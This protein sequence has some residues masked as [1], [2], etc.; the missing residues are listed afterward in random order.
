MRSKKPHLSLVIPVF[1]EEGNLAWH[2]DQITSFLE[3]RQYPY[4]LL[5]VDDGSSDNS[6]EIIKSICQKD[7]NAHY[8][9]FS[10][11][12]GKEA[13]LTAG[14]H[15]AKGDVVVGIDADGQYPLETLDDM[16]REWRSG[17]DIVIGVRTRNKGEEV[18]SR[19]GSKAFYLF[20]KMLDSNQEVI[21]AAT[22][23]RLLD[24]RVV[25]EFNKLTERNRVTRNLIDWL[26]YKRAYVE[27]EALERHSGNATYTF[28]K[29]VKL[30][31]DGIIKHSTKPLKFI[32]GVGMLVSFLSVTA[33][34]LLIIEKY[35]LG[36]PFNLAITGTAILALLLS[37]LIGI[38]LVCQGLLAL[39]LENV[40]HETQ[41]RP[42]YIVR[43]EE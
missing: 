1:N 11:N 3:K 18:V 20:L 36:D 15:K 17:S 32:G 22:D 13:A 21:S 41:N 12:F 34:I 8:L 7:S 5:Y 24:R 33:A 14:L 43:E 4:E 35:A 28:N 6:L 31:L 37:F 26:G 10:R 9:S 19:L 25:D 2:Y 42:L 23:F 30:A 16:L 27:F 40:Y 39:Y 29:R 38:V